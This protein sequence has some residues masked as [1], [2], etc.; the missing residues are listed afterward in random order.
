MTGKSR[1]EKNE[2]TVK[3]KAHS[4]KKVMK[5]LLEP[6]IAK[7]YIVAEEIKIDTRIDS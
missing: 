6:G 5:P 4:K 3:V 7:F 2:R 1:G